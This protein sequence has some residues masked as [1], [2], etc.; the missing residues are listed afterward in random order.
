MTMLL[1]ERKRTSGVNSINNQV[2]A[3]AV[4]IS[5]YLS[6]QAAFRFDPADTGPTIC[7]CTQ[8][9]KFNTDLR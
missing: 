4:V 6:A 5:V 9:Q 1:L 7:P 8:S 3:A 2:S